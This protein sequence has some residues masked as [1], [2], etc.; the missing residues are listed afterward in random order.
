MLAPGIPFI[1][2]LGI[3]YYYF[4]TSVQTTTIENIKRIVEDHRHMIESF[5]D[6]R[7]SDL[8]FVV[9]SYSPA[10][11][12]KPEKLNK[13]LLD[14]QKKSVIMLILGIFAKF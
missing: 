8:E 1:L 2:I 9:D 5:L 4:T 3:G 10:E 14:L 12:T 13:I 11:L 7:K 6:E